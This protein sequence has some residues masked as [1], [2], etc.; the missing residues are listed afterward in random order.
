MVIVGPAPT[1]LVAK[2]LANALKRVAER[3]LGY[4][5]LI[6]GPAERAGVVD[7]NQRPQCGNTEA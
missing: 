3:R 1:L 7:R 4:A 5:K 6:C 2:G